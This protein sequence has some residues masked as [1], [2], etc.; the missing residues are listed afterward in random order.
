M[1]RVLPEAYE[2]HERGGL[3]A[4]ALRAFLF[5]N[6]IRFYTEANPAFFAGTIISPELA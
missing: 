1:T 4:E 5:E 6:A 3:T 2:H